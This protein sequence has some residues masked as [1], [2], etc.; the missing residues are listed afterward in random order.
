MQ[1][2][3]LAIDNAMYAVRATL[4]SALQITPGGLAFHQ[5]TILDIPIIADLQLIQ[6]QWQQL[7]DD[8]L[9]IANRK[10]FSYDYAIGEEVLKLVYHP[11]K[12]EP[13]AIGPYRI[14]WVHANGTLTIWL[15]PT[16]IER[17]SLRQVCPYRC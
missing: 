5:D 17:I 13:R 6:E 16:T 15:S 8:W 10:W 3:D 4:H 9:I 11:N 7:I 12:L 1:L 2:V 14:E